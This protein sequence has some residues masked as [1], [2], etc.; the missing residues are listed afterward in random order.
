[1][2]TLHAIHFFVSVGSIFYE[3]VTDSSK[4]LWIYLIWPGKLVERSIHPVQ[5]IIYYVCIYEL[6]N[7]FLL[8]LWICGYYLVLPVDTFFFLSRSMFPIIT[9]LPGKAKDACKSGTGDDALTGVNGG[10]WRPLGEDPLISPLIILC[11][12]SLTELWQLLLS[13]SSSL[14]GVTSSSSKIKLGS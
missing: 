9:G 12:R 4:T 10:A 5:K 6:T 8:L 7:L 3:F 2:P 13:S 1:M 14:L 11:T